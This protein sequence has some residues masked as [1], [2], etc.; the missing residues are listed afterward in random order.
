VHTGHNR[1]SSKDLNLQDPELAAL[2]ADHGAG[3]ASALV[4]DDGTGFVSALVANY[5]AG[6]APDWG[7]T[8]RRRHSRTRTGSTSTPSV[9]C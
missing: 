2:V 9:R 3:F 7:I 6:F 8:R 5:G 4:A 1:A